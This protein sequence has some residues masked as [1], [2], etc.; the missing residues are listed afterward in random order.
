MIE[1]KA[2]DSS[3]LQV[4]ITENALLENNSIVS[5]NLKAIS[6]FGIKIS[7]DDFGTGYS[8][9]SYLK[10]LPLSALK[11]DKSFVE[12]L[13]C[14]PEDEAIALAILNLAKALNLETV[15]EGVET[16]QQLSWLRLHGCDQVQGYL[17]SKPLETEDFTA[18]LKRR[19]N[20]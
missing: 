14:D 1:S 9:L 20:N 8:S 6:Q 10:R 12:G 4:E 11:I 2:V 17:L 18:L 7:I 16:E 13:G 3:L 15:A 5:E 19:G